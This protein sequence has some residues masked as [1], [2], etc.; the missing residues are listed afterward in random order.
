MRP[1]TL[2]IGETEV[3]RIGLGTNRLTSSDDNIGLIRDAAASGVGLIDTAHT[4]TGGQSET[5]IGSALSEASNGVVVATKGGWNGANPDVLRAEIEESLR[6]LRAES[7]ALYYL[8]RPDPETPLE[9]SLAAIKEYADG[10]QIRHVGVSNVSVAE[11]ERARDV[12]PIAAVQNLYNLAD[13]T[14]DDVVDYCAREGIAFI[15]YFPLRGGGG[16]SVLVTIAQDRGATTAQ[17]ALAWLL[18]RSPTMLPIPGTL[19]REHLHEN[20]RALEIE[21]GEDD[22]RV[23]S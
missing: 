9:Q 4:Y 14:H 18:A 3:A 17:I 20:V 21:L 1:A 15:P 19:S 16:G 7:I 22:L 23:L 6:R 11:V 2:M 12:V 10:G 5:T 13:R 8:H